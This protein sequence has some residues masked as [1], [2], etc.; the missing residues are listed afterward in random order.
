MNP[1]KRVLH[2]LTFGRGN[3]PEAACGETQ[4]LSNTTPFPLSVECKRCIEWLR[5]CGPRIPVEA[6]PGAAGEVES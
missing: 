2:Y 5:E 6:A 3:A 1:G 4:L